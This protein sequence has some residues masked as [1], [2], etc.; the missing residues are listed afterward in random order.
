MPSINSPNSNPFPGLGGALL[1]LAA[2]VVAQA[3][4]A[5]V[6]N[7][8]WPWRPADTSLLAGLA[9]LTALSA[10]VMFA[11]V[12]SGEVPRF[13]SVPDA[14][15]WFWAGLA[16]SATGGTVVLG[17][18]ANLTTQML[19]LSPGLARLFNQL[20]NGNLLVSLFTLSLVAPL[21]EEAL[22]RG[23]LLRSFARRWGDTPGLVLSSALFAGFHLN[24]W[25]APAA[26]LAGLFLGWVFLRTRSL[27]YPIA[28]HALFNGLPVILTAAGFSVTGYNTPLSTPVE[29][30]PPLWIA[31]GIIVLATGLWMTKRWAP[32]SP[33]L[34]SDT[35]EP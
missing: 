31:A 21:T 34:V 14:G 10:V 12:Q 20:T 9:N 3:A 2:A 1:L 22:F 6:L 16:L 27:L 17:E 28:A 26:F 32:L 25:Q 7:G 13:S 4:A 18:L 8:L 23:V 5:F 11:F 29:F 35:V 19:P 30:Q 15:P 24:V 33:P